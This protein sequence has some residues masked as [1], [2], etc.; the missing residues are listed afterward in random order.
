MIGV[1]LIDTHAELVE[2]W[3]KLKKLHPSD[4]RLQEFLTPPFSEQEMLDIA[5]TRWQDSNFRAQTCA[6]W[7][8]EARNKYLKLSKKT[9]YQITN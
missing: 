6:R 5:A 2:A 4:V 7:A 9:R 8:Q 1:W 3:R